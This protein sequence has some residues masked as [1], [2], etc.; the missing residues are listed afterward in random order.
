MQALADGAILAGRERSSGTHWP[1]NR[2]FVSSVWTLAA[3]VDAHVRR[4]CVRAGDIGYE[5]IVAQP[6]LFEAYIHVPAG[7]SGAGLTDKMWILRPAAAGCN[8]Y[9]EKRTGCER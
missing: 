5:L 1:R 9:E 7:E 6:S 3:I 4:G 8:Q 2:G